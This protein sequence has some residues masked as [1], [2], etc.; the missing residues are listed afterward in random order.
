METSRD[1][2]YLYHIYD[3][4]HSS[5]DLQGGAAMTLSWEEKFVNRRVNKGLEAPSDTSAPSGNM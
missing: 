2:I 1:T 5:A 3:Q 4:G